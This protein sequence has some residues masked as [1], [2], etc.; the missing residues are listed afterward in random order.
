M[1]ANLLRLANS[2]FFGCR[3]QITSVRQAVTLLGAARVCDIASSAAFA[4]T[5]PKTIPGYNVE[6][7]SFWTHCMAVAAVSERIAMEIGLKAPSLTFTAG[8]LHDVGKLVV[9]SYLMDESERIIAVLKTEETTLVDAERQALGTDH[10][11]IGGMICDKWDLPDAI[12]A[13][14]RM[15]H[16]PNDAMSDEN[17]VLVDLVHAADCLAHMLGFG[18]DVGELSRRFDSSVTK[19]IG[20]KVQRL[21]HAASE[22]IEQIHSMGQLFEAP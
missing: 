7:R 1:T 18:T 19:R 14:V 5:M 15:H 6:A 3:R 12:G 22:S 10:A 17:T 2:P 4:R 8:L 11:E 16:R 13:V 21:E 9:G 20:I